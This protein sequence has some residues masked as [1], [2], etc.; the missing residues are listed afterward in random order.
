MLDIFI[1]NFNMAEHIRGHGY[2]K[3]LKIVDFYF[4]KDELAINQERLF[5]N[6]MAI[7]MD[8]KHLLQ[9]V[10]IQGL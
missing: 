4:V 3:F 5:G 1:L 7:L 6:F 9:H 10:Q 2:T 8:A